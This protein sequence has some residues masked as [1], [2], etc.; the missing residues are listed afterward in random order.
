MPADELA[1]A[2][3]AADPA[4]L[5]TVRRIRDN[6]LQFQIGLLRT[7]AV[8]PVSGTTSCSCATGRSGA[9]ASASP[10]GRPRTRPRC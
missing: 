9:S 4:F 10:A 7:D 2:H 1:A 3:A 5:D 6:V 8:L